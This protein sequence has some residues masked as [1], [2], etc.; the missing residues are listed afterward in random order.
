MDRTLFS[1]IWK[2]SKRQQILLLFFTLVSFPFLYA[3]LELPKRIINDA[4]GAPSGTVEAFG[5]T[6]TQVEYLL[7][8]CFAFLAAVLLSGMMKI[9][10]SSLSTIT[11]WTIT[12]SPIHLTMT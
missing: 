4:I 6:M 12:L 7:L 2:H 10:I 8:L 1:F 9:W 5:L 3:S 11:G